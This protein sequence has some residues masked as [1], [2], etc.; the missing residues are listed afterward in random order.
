MSASRL[1][2]G[3]MI[4]Q[5]FGDRGDVDDFGKKSINQ[6]I[7]SLGIVKDDW[8]EDSLVFELANGFDFRLYDGGQSCCESRYMNTDDDLNYF[9]GST[10]MDI[11][12]A[13]G[14]SEPGTYG[15]ALDSEFLIVKTSLGEFTVV[16]YNNHNGYYGGFWVK[17]GVIN[18]IDASQI[19]VPKMIEHEYVHQYGEDIILRLTVNGDEPG[20]KR[21]TVEAIHVD[22]SGQPFATQWGRTPNQALGWLVQMP[23]FWK[24][25]GVGVTIAGD[26]EEMR[27]SDPQDIPA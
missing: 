10:L 27:L 4:E 11:R 17:V 7:T 22:G 25:V 14:P 5:L 21:W 18:D 6:A 15:D 20:P 1:G 3:V 26:G 8:T 23:A 24:E 16:N 13:S 12:M 19:V 9:V 2:L